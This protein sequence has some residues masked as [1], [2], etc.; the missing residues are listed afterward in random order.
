M[1]VNK[2][3][4]ML[5]AIMKTIHGTLYAISMNFLK[6]QVGLCLCLLRFHFFM[7]L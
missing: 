1:E 2:T 7:C 3:H 5:R 6:G 4:H